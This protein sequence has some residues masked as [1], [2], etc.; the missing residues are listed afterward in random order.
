MDGNQNENTAYQFYLNGGE[1]SLSSNEFSFN[2]N[3][4]IYS[5]SISE[6]GSNLLTVESTSNPEGCRLERSFAVEFVNPIVYSGERDFQM[7]VCDT[8]Y[9]LTISMDDI[10]GGNPLIVENQPL[11]DLSWNYTSLTQEQQQFIGNV[12][13]NAQPGTYDLTITDQ[14]GCQ[15]LEEFITIRLTG[16]QVE[17]FTRLLVCWLIPRM[18]NW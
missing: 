10:H 14:N 17:P 13:P 11:Y 8:S 7:S 2:E 1:L 12:I 4:Q 3:T 15:N 16:P 6:Q 9:A 5:L 18:E